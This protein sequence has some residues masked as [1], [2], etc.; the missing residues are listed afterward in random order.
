MPAKKTANKHHALEEWKAKMQRC[1]GHPE[2]N[3]A[4]MYKTN[5]KVPSSQDI[6]TPRILTMDNGCQFVFNRKNGILRQSEFHTGNP[7][8]NPVK[9]IH[10][11]YSNE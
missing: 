1:F 8:L 10:D 9:Y 11:Y 7:I 4:S 6:L 2:F 5:Y 3:I